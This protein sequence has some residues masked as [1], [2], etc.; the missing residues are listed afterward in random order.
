MADVTKLRELLDAYGI[1]VRAGVI[2]PCLED[3]NAFRLRLGLDPASESVVA[4]WK[5]SKGVRAPITLARG[6]GTEGQVADNI[7]GR[8]VVNDDAE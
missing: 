7:T 4:D 6:V 1:A 3:E 2:T 5:K 8:E